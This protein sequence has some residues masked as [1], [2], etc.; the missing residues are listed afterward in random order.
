MLALGLNFGFSPVS[1]QERI[2]NEGAQE[3]H[4]MKGP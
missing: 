3:S 1:K 2:Q 4:C